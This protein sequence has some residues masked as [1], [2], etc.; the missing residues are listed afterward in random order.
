M[1]RSAARC[2]GKLSN[3]IRRKLETFSCRS[4]FSGAQGK[5]LHFLLAQPHDVFQKDVEHVYGMRPSTATELLKQMEKNG[6]IFR[7][8][9][10]HDNRLK[11]IVLTEKALQHK[12]QV[13][14]D[15][16]GL[17]NTLTSG[18]SEQDM[19]IFFSVVEKMTENLSQ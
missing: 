9:V 10:E 18:I 1:D 7:E 17:E 4:D 3:K 6:L 19:E 8:P 11:R 15:L 16:G 2:I 14:E 5:V 12:T 13:M